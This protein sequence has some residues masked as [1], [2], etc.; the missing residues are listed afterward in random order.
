MSAAESAHGTDHPVHPGTGTV[1]PF[2]AARPRRHPRSER[3]TVPIQPDGPLSDDERMAAKLEQVFAQ[4]GRSLTDEN[5]AL[6]VGIILGEWRK[7][8]ARAREAGRIDD[9]AHQSLDGMLEAMIAAA[10]LLA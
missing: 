7:I 4:H 1:L 2:P 10:A 8:L 6:D 3:T 9:V 5:T